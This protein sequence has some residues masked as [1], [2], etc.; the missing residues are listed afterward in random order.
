[1]P[2]GGGAGATQLNGGP[3][4]IDLK[5]CMSLLKKTI[6]F[7]PLLIMVVIFLIKAYL[8]T[9]PVKTQHVVRLI[10]Y[11]RSKEQASLVIRGRYVPSFWIANLESADK[12]T[13]FGWKLSF[14]I[15]FSNVN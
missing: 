15:I 9:D 3:E 4:V 7:F 13:I 12:K 5:V 10:K 2:A 11:P 1:M 14:R 6:V 8:T